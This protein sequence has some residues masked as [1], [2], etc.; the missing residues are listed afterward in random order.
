VYEIYECTSDAKLGAHY[1]QNNADTMTDI[2]AN[3][4][5]GLVGGLWPMASICRAHERRCRDGTSLAD[6]WNQWS[7]PR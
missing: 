1:Q 6:K 2:L 4:V 3:D 7:V 5:G